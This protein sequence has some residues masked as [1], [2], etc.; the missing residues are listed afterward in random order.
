MLPSDERTWEVLIRTAILLL[1]PV[2]DHILHSKWTPLSPI[3]V[4]PSVASTKTRH[5][6]SRLVRA[7]SDP[8]P[9]LLQLHHHP[10]NGANAGCSVHSFRSKGS[11]HLA[12]KRRD[13]LHG[14]KPLQGSLLALHIASPLRP[15]DWQPAGTR[16]LNSTLWMA[17]V[18]GLELLGLLCSVMKIERN[19]SRFAKYLLCPPA[20]RAEIRPRAVGPDTSAWAGDHT[21]ARIHFSS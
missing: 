17:V 12:T 19:L 7:A 11:S 16:A 5:I 15:S 13:P 14:V 21:V 10:Q 20:D 2:S 4:V 1:V 18:V 6:I 8:S 9:C 3:C